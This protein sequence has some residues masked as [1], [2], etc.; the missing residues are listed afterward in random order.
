MKLRCEV[1]DTHANPPRFIKAVT[2]KY[3]DIKFRVKLGKFRREYRIVYVKDGKSLVKD[4]GKY[5]LYQTDVHNAV[6]AISFYPYEA[7]KVNPV[8]ADAMLEEGLAEVFI[9]KGGMPFWYLLVVL[10]PLAIAVVALVY[11]VTQSTQNHDLAQQA[12]NL[13]NT[14]HLKAQ[15]YAAQ[16]SSMGV[17]PNPNYGNNPNITIQK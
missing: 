16:I 10:I 15:A 7:E 1:W 11:F 3:G 6:G 2:K 13:Y 8:E 5:F 4:M 12:V 14:E 17:T 9:R